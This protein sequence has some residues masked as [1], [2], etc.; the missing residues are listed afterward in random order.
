[1]TELLEFPF[2]QRSFQQCYEHIK[3]VELRHAPRLSNDLE[4]LLTLKR[5]VGETILIMATGKNVTFSTIENDI[6]EIR[7]LGFDDI[8]KEASI[9]HNLIFHYRKD[10][11]QRESK[12]VYKQLLK[13]LREQLAWIASTIEHLEECPPF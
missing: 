2:T 11:D 5:C 13:R 3:G 10:V 9:I 1:M 7:K 12:K 8:T 4:S 6:K